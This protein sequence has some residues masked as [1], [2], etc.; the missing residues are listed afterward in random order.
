[1]VIKTK[2]NLNT[3]KKAKYK[4]NIVDYKW[5]KVN[6]LYLSFIYLVF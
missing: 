3:I 4:H 2:K 6:W 1:M 5:Q